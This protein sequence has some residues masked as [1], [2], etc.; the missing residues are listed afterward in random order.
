MPNTPAQ[1]LA[2]ARSP[3][4]GAQNPHRRHL[5]ELALTG[6]AMAALGPMAW[7][8]TGAPK[9][10]GTLTIGAD[11]DPIG[12]DPVTLTA[13]SSYDF[14]AL[15]YT[16]LLRWNA[17]MKVEPDL[18]TGFLN[19]DETT[20][21]FRLRQGVKFHNGQPFTAEDVKY[22]FDRILDPASAS[23]SATLFSGIKAVTVI[24][25]FT[26]KFELRAPS[27][28]FLSYL[29]TNPNGVIVPR[30]VADLKTKPVGTGPFMFESYEP[31]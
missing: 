30:G 7:A 11:A 27:A 6:G 20:Y 3:A 5:L 18:A 22:T 15:L 9:R 12:L 16:G 28:T 10:G 29:A 14:T 4:D 1:E 13:F 19:P 24:E 21:I 17:D 25:P 26:V 23:P 2:I 31:N 8:Q